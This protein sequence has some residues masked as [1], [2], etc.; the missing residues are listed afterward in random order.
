MRDLYDALKSRDADRAESVARQEVTNA[1]I[2]IMR[3]LEETAT[4][5]F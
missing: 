2:E 1:R 4:D 5:S 3:I